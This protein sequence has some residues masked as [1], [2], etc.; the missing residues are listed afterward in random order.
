LTT[1]LEKS[2][3]RQSRYGDGTLIKPPQDPLTDLPDEGT[4]TLDTP[5]RCWEYAMWEMSV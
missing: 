5:G 1:L 3:A 4:L 2:P